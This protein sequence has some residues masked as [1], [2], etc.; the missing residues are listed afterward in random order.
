[1]EKIRRNPELR[2]LKTAPRY[3]PEFAF[4]MRLPVL[5]EFL[6]WNFAMLIA[7]K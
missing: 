6:A 2:V 7:R 1:M 4:L 5:R 3:Y